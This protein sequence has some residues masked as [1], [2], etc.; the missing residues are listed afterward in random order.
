MNPRTHAI[1]L[2]LALFFIGAP[3]VAQES[4]LVGQ[5]K[6]LFSDQGCYGCH[7]VGK[8]GTPMGPDLSRVGFKYRE[9]YL[10]Q[11]LRDPSVQKP[12]AHM[13]KIAMT[14]SEAR[15]LAAFLAS[16]K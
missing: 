12:T 8:T 11:W 7:T 3:T 16:L 14:E 10:V 9:S 1:L 5:G 6:K 15:A 4:T 2:G 13:P